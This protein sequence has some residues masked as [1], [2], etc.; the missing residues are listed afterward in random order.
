MISVV[1]LNVVVLTS[2][3]RTEKKYP[4]SR[5]ISNINRRKRRRMRGRSKKIRRRIIKKRGG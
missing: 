1:P 5:N 3:M 2:Q 4:T